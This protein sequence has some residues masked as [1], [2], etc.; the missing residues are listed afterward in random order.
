MS[1]DKIKQYT[2]IINPVDYY[3]FNHVQEAFDFMIKLKNVKA[4]SMDAFAYCKNKGDDVKRMVV[5]E[6]DFFV[7][8]M[9]NGL[10]LEV[11]KKYSPFMLLQKFVFKDSFTKALSYVK[12][13]HMNLDCAYV[14]V[15]TKY[16]KNISKTDRYGVNR[17][18]LVYWEKTTLLEDYSTQFIE[19]IGKYDDFTIEPNNKDYS[20]VVNNN[21]NLY[22]KFEHSPCSKEEYDEEI[23]FY[24]IKT[25]VEH[26]FGEQVELGFKYLKI[27]YD[28][29]KQ[30]LPILVL[31]SEERQTGK[32]TFVD[33][34][35]I[36]FGANMV[37]INPQDISNGFNGSYSDKNIIAIEE[38]R[39]D[40]VQATEKLKNL[41]TQKEILVNSKHIRQYSIPFYGKLI[42][43]SNDE[44]KF[45]KV[46][47]P[48]IRYWVRKIPSLKG[49]GN[50]QILSDIRNEIPQF[51][52]YLDTL[53]EV[54]TTKS[55]MVF[56]ASEINTVELETVKNESKAGLHK[57]IEM[58]LDQ[59]S[60]EN[61]KVSEF[62]FT[63]LHIK[64]R[65]FKNDHKN[66]LNYFNKILK[67]SMKLERLKMQRFIPLEANDSV[68]MSKVSGTP[69]VFKNPYY[70]ETIIGAAK[71]ISEKPGTKDS[72]GS[73]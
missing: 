42:I 58:Y 56:E 6:N 40:S 49:K 19:D 29:P 63:A 33:F 1:D 35:N 10:H 9:E 44:T 62:K 54:D 71:T 12:T 31:I 69:F 15:G 14:R 18:E 51:L 32:T 27:L 2:N 66:E 50:H 17:T 34:L 25:L 28:N 36:L 16:F 68:L 7:A 30:A 24:W 73:Y 61:N 21:Y 65:F 67:D 4:V 37:I 5:I 72:S 23:G 70:E 45:S 41:A 60:I 39:F 38:S 20:R 8:K 46:D 55:R 48:E 59:Y 3:N 22:S 47:N 11:D 43:T 52:Y 13:K 64:E 53:P 26:I 57:D